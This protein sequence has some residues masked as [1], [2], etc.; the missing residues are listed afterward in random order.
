[1][2]LRPVISMTVLTLV[3]M[4]IE[5]TR[6][7]REIVKLHEVRFVLLFYAIMFIGVPFAVHLWVAFN[8]Q[9]S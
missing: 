4:L 3:L 1:M 9:S 7:P 8:A 2:P 6:I 5:R